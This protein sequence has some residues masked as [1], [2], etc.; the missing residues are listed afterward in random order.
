MHDGMAVALQD[1]YGRTLVALAEA[2]AVAGRAGDYLV[3]VLHDRPTGRYE[4]A[5]GYLTW[6][7]PA[8]DTT[9]RLDVAVADVVDGRF[10][11][12]LTVYVAAERNGRTYAAQQCSFRWHPDLY[13]YTTDMRLPAGSYD[14]TIR[15]ASGFPRDDRINGRRHTEPVTLRIPDVDLHRS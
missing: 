6:R 7:E 10:V 2:G 4:A 14:L 5:G 11:P 13:R 8:P 1:R 9:V 3:L 12:H 15:V